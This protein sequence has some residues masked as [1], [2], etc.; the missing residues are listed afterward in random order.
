L[1]DLRRLVSF[2]VLFAAGLLLGAGAMMAVHG[3][4]APIPSFDATGRL[5]ALPAGP[6]DVIAETVRLGRGFKGRHEHGGPT[7]NFV[8]A[9]RVRI[10]E[11]DGTVTQFGPGGFFFEPGG[12]PHTIEVLSD[13]R[14]DVLHLVPAG[15]AATTDLPPPHAKPPG[16]A[17]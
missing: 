11:D 12:R 15:S 6:A 10:I 3:S 16:D 2:L 5:Q 8:M 4:S 7:F 13:V 1:R 9:G 14:L 17:G